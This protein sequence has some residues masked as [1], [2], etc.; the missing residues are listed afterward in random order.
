MESGENTTFESWLKANL[1]PSE[2]KDLASHGA[3][4][5]WPGLT[6][7][8]ETGELYEK[9]KEEIWKALSDDA[10]ELGHKSVFEMIAQFREATSVTCVES[11]ENLM[12]WYMAERTAHRLDA[13][14]D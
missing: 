13:L 10:D 7:Y 11:F 9:Y 3:D 5:G 6:Y 4:A 1:E 8:S 2:I 12:V 14:E